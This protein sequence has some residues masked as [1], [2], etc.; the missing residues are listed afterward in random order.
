MQQQNVESTM[1]KEEEEEEAMDKEP[2]V[3]RQE[4]E[5]KAQD[6]DNDNNKT[7]QHHLQQ[8]Q[9]Q[10]QQQSPRLYL[11]I[12]NIQ[13]IAN[14]KAMLLS[15]IAFGCCEVLMVGQENNSKRKDM[16]PLPFQEAVNNG[17]ILLTRFP[18][19][20]DCVAYI[21]KQKIFLIGVEI[22]ETSQLLN[23]E[24]FES[25][26]YPKNEKNIGIFMGNEG[27]GILPVHLKNCNSLIQIPQH[28][29]GTAS[30]NVNVATSI[31]LYRFQD[32]KKRLIRNDHRI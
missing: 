4:E 8:Q 14:I 15:S 2:P 7:Q 11:V 20:R 5:Q 29:V 31:V 18:K 22:D 24:Y 25:T 9:Q 19:W 32:Y 26:H 12:C 27:Q 1:I 23:D 3:Q 6:D 16:F 13:K 28:G 30:M 10:Q 17:Q 21:E